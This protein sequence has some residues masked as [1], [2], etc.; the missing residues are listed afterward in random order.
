METG[1]DATTLV[2]RQIWVDPTTASNSLPPTCTPFVLSSGGLINIG[3]NTVLTLTQDAAFQP[4]CPGTPVPQPLDPTQPGVEAVLNYQDPFYSST[5][6]QIYAIA[7]VTVV[8]YTLVIILFITPRTFFVGGAGGGGGFLGQGGMVGGTYGSNSIIGVG[9]RPWLQKAATVA[10]AISLTIVTADTFKWAEIQY[11]AGYDDA[12]ELTVKVIDGLEIRVVRVISETFLWL[13][14]A[15]TLIRLFPRHKEKLVIKWTAFGLITL[16]VVFSSLNQLV[17]KG[18]KS[19]PKNFVNAIPALDYLFALA[20]NLCYAAFVIYYSMV[21]RRFAFWNKK[22]RNMPLVA[23]L[24]LTAVLIPVIFFILDLSQPNVSGWG[25]YVRWVGAAAASV[26]VWEWVERIEALERDE[27]KDGILGREIFDGDEMLE[28][29]PSSEL[30]FSRTRNEKRIRRGGGHDGGFGHSMSTGWNNLATRAKRLHK[31]FRL[32]KK[33]QS[34]LSGPETRY[35]ESTDQPEL[36]RKAEQHQQYHHHP[37]PRPPALVASPVSRAE[38]ASAASTVYMVRYHPVTE[39][40]PPIPEAA[41]EDHG[42]LKPPEAPPETEGLTR[43]RDHTAENATMT[44]A[45]SSGFSRI[46]NPFRRQRNSP[47]LEVA[48]AMSSNPQETA[49]ATAPANKESLWQRLHL[50]TSPKEDESPRRLIVVPAP[51]RRRPSPVTEEGNDDETHSQED[52]REEYDLS[53]TPPSA[54]RDCPPDAVLRAI[55]SPQPSNRGSEQSSESRA[56]NITCN[57]QMS[58]RGTLLISENRGLGD[59]PVSPTTLD[60]L[61][62]DDHQR[63]EDSALE[64][65]RK[66]WTDHD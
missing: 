61:A 32:R 45:L 64:T 28:N 18:G 39:P 54:D 41:L 3:R 11:N 63:L 38:T 40:T 59:Q 5:N 14:Q 56:P 34:A 24:S 29:T 7:A 44:S 60:P 33:Q 57:V 27:K 17:D 36:Q 30:S 58:R 9:S 46:L 66:G 2:P 10:V 6:P 19:Y 42:E 53:F 15:Q 35:S 8:S 52:R 21:K 23:L 62:T 49:I 65:R 51:Q 47:P 48:Q 43:D 55:S 31:P 37:F 12:T 4:L 20:L 16:E 22:M 13:A 25:S 26:I 50:K 1:V